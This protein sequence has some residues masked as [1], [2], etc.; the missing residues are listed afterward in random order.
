MQVNLA[1]SL[2]NFKEA[3]RSFTFCEDIEFKYKEQLTS[4]EFQGHIT[5]LLK[6]LELIYKKQKMSEA[7]RANICYVYAQWNEVELHL[8]EKANKSSVF[9]AD[10]KIYLEGT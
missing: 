4:L 1:K 7:N 5:K 9:A 10:L 6:L 3:L 2:E 8:K